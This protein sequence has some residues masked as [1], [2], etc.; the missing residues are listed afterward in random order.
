[1]VHCL[2]SIFTRYAKGGKLQAS[3]Y[4]LLQKRPLLSTR[5]MPLFTDRFCIVQSARSYKHSSMVEH[6]VNN[7]TDPGSNP[8]V[9]SQRQPTETLLSTRTMQ[10]LFL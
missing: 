3:K 6:L 8:G 2:P 1:M 10:S 5:V 4:A 9:A 7:Q